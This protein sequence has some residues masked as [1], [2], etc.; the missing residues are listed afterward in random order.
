LHLP[1][2]LHNDGLYLS[3]F[4][5]PLGIEV[6]FGEIFALENVIGHLNFLLLEVELHHR[7][8]LY[9]DPPDI[10]V[11]VAPEAYLVDHVCK[12]T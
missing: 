6:C 9:I 12:L 10:A 3:N 1:E 2:A 7:I 8:V 11:G 5:D 4:L